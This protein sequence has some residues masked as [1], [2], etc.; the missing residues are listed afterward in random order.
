MAQNSTQ[1]KLEIYSM[2]NT[3]VLLA[4]LVTCVAAFPLNAQSPEEIGATVG[5]FLRA[6]YILQEATTQCSEFGLQAHDSNADLRDVTATKWGAAFTS[7]VLA[8]IRKEASRGVQ[9]IKTATEGKGREFYCGFFIGTASQGHLLR[10]NDWNRLK[11]TANRR[12]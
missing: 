7:D 9:N 10:R 2:R 12:N 5:S 6:S 8:G 11:A 3:C 1:V 4:L